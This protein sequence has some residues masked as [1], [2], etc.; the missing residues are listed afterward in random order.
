MINQDQKDEIIRFVLDASDKEN[1]NL[2]V[3]IAVLILSIP[4]LV[5]YNFSTIA[6]PTK[7]GPTDYVY[8]KHSYYSRAVEGFGYGRM[9]NEGFNNIEDYNEQPVDILLMGSS[10][11]EGLQ[12]PQDKTTASLLNKLFF[13]KEYVY[14]IGMGGHDFSIIANNFEAAI[15]QYAPKQYVI[16][17]TGSIQFSMQTLIDIINYEIPENILESN[18]RGPRAFLRTTFLKNILYVRLFAYQVKQFRDKANKGKPEGL[19]EFNKDDYL[20]NINMVMQR[21]NQTTIEN[22]TRLIIFFHP[23]LTLNRDGS[24]SANTNDEYL[25][26]FKAACINNGIYFLDMTAIF[27]EEY[28]INHILP[29]GFANT[30]VGAG[31][32]NKNGHRIIAN[33]LFR[34]INEIEKGG[35]L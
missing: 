12:V 3:F 6:I 5:Y 7:G 19:D 9:N 18:I 32:L 10:Q 26:A 17:E 23:H 2:A 21:L 31:H 30:A 11:M 28:Q 34:G 4:C 16:I 15:K 24:A 20:E 27:M 1:E 25:D 33:E 22:N 35:S 8:K 14:N 29:Y 13:G